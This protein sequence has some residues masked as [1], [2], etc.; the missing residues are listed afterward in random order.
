MIATLLI[1]MF[2]T[3]SL[4]IALAQAGGTAGGA[5]TAALR[6]LHGAVSNL[7]PWR[8]RS[9]RR[10]A[11]GQIAGRVDTVIKMLPTRRHQ[12]AFTIG[13]QAR[14][15]ARAH[16]HGAVA[17]VPQAP[18]AGAAAPG[19]ASAAS[20][21]RR[22]RWRV[23]LTELQVMAITLTAALPSAANVAMLAE[24]YGAD[25]GRN[26]HHHGLD[27]GVVR[28][29]HVARRAVRRARV[30][31]CAISPADRRRRPSARAP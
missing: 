12:G 19:A 16:A 23:P 18:A 26:A 10:S 31:A 17:T 29:L 20:A 1:D 30:R 7:L 13:G 14:R 2:V 3:S 24:R 6:L 27:H 11:F 9:A 4:C 8:S 28:H 22:G 25:N 21:T 5:R 15:P